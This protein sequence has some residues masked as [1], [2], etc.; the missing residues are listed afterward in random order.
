MRAAIIAAML[1][2]GCAHKAEPV[3]RTVTVKV[4]VAVPCLRADQ[5]PPQPPGLGSAPAT[6]QEALSVAL[7]RLLDWRDWGAHVEALILACSE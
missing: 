3:V 7:G 4:P 2:A 1:L 6:Q 5:I